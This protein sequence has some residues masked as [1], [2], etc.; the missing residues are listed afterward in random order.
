MVSEVGRLKR[1]DA[2]ELELAEAL[3][4]VDRRHGYSAGSADC[5][6]ASELRRFTSGK[7]TRSQADSIL[8]HIGSCQH[9]MAVLTKVRTQRLLVKRAYVTMAAAVAILIAAWILKGRHSLLPREIATIDLRPFSPTRGAESG[10]EPVARISRRVRILQAVLPIGSEGKYECTIRLSREGFP[11]ARS[12]GE[13][14]LDS[15]RVVLN[16]PIDLDSL[17][18]GRYLLALRRN[19]SEWAFYPVE[20]K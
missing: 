17:P 6:S 11:V 18:P 20:L 9:C 3:T 16:L 5:P 12:S 10:V 7:C 15:G 13:T 8:V 2:P 14:V 19:G 4:D 1:S